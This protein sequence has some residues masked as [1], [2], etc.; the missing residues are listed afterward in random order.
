MMSLEEVSTPYVDTLTL[1]RKRYEENIGSSIERNESKDMNSRNTAMKNGV[2]NQTSYFMNNAVSR[3]GLSG[4]AL[5]D[6]VNFGAPFPLLAFCLI[7][8]AFGIQ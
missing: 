4:K 6:Q 1:L 3:G 2:S 5:E 7:S 8:F